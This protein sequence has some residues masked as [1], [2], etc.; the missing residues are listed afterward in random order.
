MKKLFKPIYLFFLKSFFKK[1]YETRGTAGPITMRTLIVQKLI[2]INRKAYWPTHFTTV[3]SSPENI[4]IGVGTA[5]GLSPGCY[6]QGGGS[7]VIGDYTIVGPNVGIISAN[8]NLY[9]YN[10][11]DKGRIEIGR[12]C[13]I[14][15]NSIVLPNVILG[16][17]VIVAAG[18]VV[19]KSF[20]EGYCVIGGTP[21]R[22]IKHLDPGQIEEPK[23]RFEY[24]GYI[25]KSKFEKFRSRALNV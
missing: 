14:G 1:N 24:Y 25:P 10:I 19:T 21:A 16:D 20:D 3:V 17:H 4:K 2:G 18:S 8:H 11:A 5:P 13:W 12:Y 6:I 15:M 22:L 7:I 23:N 9:N